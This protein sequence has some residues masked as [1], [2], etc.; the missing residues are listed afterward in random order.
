MPAVY[1]TKEQLEALDHRMLGSM[2][3]CIVITHANP[4][5]NV[6]GASNEA[7]RAIV[8]AHPANTGITWVEFGAAAVEAQCYP[9]NKDE[10]FSGPVTNTNKINCLFKVGGEKVTVAYSN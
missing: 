4:D 6:A 8:K 10:S 7:K 1:L 5:T 9:L 3:E 2:Q